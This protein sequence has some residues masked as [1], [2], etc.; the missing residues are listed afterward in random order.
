MRL[1]H[2]FTVS[3]LELRDRGLLSKLFEAEG[4]TSD[5]G[6][7]KRGDHLQLG[8]PNLSFKHQRLFCKNTT[9]REQS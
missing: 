3:N 2:H 7:V 4:M 8:F 1:H 9:V 5:A 6:T